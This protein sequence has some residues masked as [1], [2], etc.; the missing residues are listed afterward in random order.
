M[1]GSFRFDESSCAKQNKKRIEAHPQ[2][3][4][5]CLLRDANPSNRFA[6]PEADLVIFTPIGP[7]TAKSIS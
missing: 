3:C 6:P 4:T 1:T 2:L 7:D 5:N